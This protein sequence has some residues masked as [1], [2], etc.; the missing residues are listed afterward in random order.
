MDLATLSRYCCASKRT[1]R[2]WTNRVDNPLPAR[3]VG[4]KLFVARAAFD[5]WMAKQPPT[6]T[7]QN[8]DK[9]VDEIVASVTGGN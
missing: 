3:H 2:D 9:I 1:L 6:G 5:E 8:I 7:S 4:G